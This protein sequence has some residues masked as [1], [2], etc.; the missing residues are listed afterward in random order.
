[1][2]NQETVRYLLMD[3]VKYDSPANDQV[4]MA[5]IERTGRTS[6][7]NKDEI[8]NIIRQLG[9][10]GKLAQN[11]LWSGPFNEF[12]AVH[13]EYRIDCNEG[14]LVQA[15]VREGK[16]LNF[17]D[18]MY[19]A[20]IP[21]V[22]SRLAVTAAGQAQQQAAAQA[23]KEVKLAEEY[24]KEML[25]WLTEGRREEQLKKANTHYSVYAGEVKR[26]TAR[27]AGMNY[28][29]LAEEITRRREV[30]RL[31][32]LDAKAI[33][34]ELAAQHTQPT[35]PQP[36]PQPQAREN[37]APNRY[38]KLP[39]V[40]RARSGQEIPMTRKGLIELSNRDAFSFREVVRRF[41]A[42]AVNDILAGRI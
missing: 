3:N 8:R 28:E 39:E 34:T 25:S 29:Q 36:A 5:Y 12:Y 35:A 30:R 14:I 7:L 17:D 20:G 21:E 22:Q 33:R 6:Q 15:L 23:A 41:G 18:L 2:N 11:P 42:D 37:A 13:P 16:G 31:R 24:R 40:Y 27:L 9:A 1:M 26:E 4:V 19:I 10:E 38:E 32:G